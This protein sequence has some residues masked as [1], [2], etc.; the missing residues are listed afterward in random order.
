VSERD[1]QPCLA[2]G[3]GDSPADPD[4][5]GDAADDV[6]AAVADFVRDLVDEGEAP[7]RP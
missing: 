6:V 7:G 2:V 5:G 3:A 4:N 1:Q